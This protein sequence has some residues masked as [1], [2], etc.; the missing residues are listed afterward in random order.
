MLI[1]HLL[2]GSLKNV[3]CKAQL[4]TLKGMSE[5]IILR[6][7]VRSSQLVTNDIARYV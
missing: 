1:V 6:V 2:A 5:I 4:F 3:L 7:Y